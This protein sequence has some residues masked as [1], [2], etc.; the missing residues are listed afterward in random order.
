MT[1]QRIDNHHADYTIYTDGLATLWS[2][3]DG[4]AVVIT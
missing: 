2:K 3:H 4:F 1:T